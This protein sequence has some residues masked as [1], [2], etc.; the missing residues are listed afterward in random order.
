MKRVRP[1]DGTGVHRRAARYHMSRCTSGGTPLHKT[2]HAQMSAR[3]VALVASARATEDAED[4]EVAAGAVLD[5][6]EASLEN[7]IRDLDSELQKLDRKDETLGAQLAVFPEGYGAVIDPEEDEQLLELG[8][9]RKRV[10]PFLN[11][12]A[13]ADTMTRLDDA[14]QALKDAITLADEAE[15]TASIAFAAENGARAAVRE[16]IESAYGQLR[17]LYKS[18]PKQAEKFFQK[19]TGSRRRPAKEAPAVPPAETPPA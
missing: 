11:E 14:E 17:S 13:I 7:V 8:P 3:Y 10:D 6:A 19:D 5:A 1:T 4:A 2:L 15:K 12:A 9:L 16:Q 18:R